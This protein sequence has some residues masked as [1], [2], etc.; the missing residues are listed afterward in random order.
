MKNTESFI[1]WSVTTD[2]TV[3]AQTVFSSFENIDSLPAIPQQQRY[4][5]A[6]LFFH[7]TV[8]RPKYHPAYAK[9]LNLAFNVLTA[10][11][12]ILQSV[13]INQLKVNNCYAIVNN[14]DDNAYDDEKSASDTSNV[15][16]FHFSLDN[17][18]YADILHFCEI[19]S[20]TGRE[21][22]VTKMNERQFIHY[23]EYIT[24]TDNTNIQRSYHEVSNLVFKRCPD[25]PSLPFY[26]EFAFNHGSILLGPSINGVY[27]RW[28]NLNRRPIDYAN[29][30]FRIAESALQLEIGT[31]EQK[32]KQLNFHFHPDKLL[33]KYHHAYQPFITIAHTVLQTAWALIKEDIQNSASDSE[34]E[35]EY[36]N[37]IVK[38]N[39]DL[40]VNIEFPNDTKLPQMKQVIDCCIMSIAV[41][42][43]SE[44]MDNADKIIKSDDT[45]NFDSLSKSLDLLLQ[46]IQ[47]MDIS[48]PNQNQLKDL[49]VFE[50][51]SHQVIKTVPSPDLQSNIPSQSST[52]NSGFLSSAQSLMQHTIQATSDKYVITFR[53]SAHFFVH[54]NFQYFTDQNQMDLSQVTTLIRDLII[55]TVQSDL[56]CYASNCPSVST[57]L[58][59]LHHTLPQLC[60]ICRTLEEG[61]IH[62][63]AIQTNRGQF[64]IG[65]F[66]VE[67]VGDMP[68]LYNRPRNV[69]YYT[70]SWYQQIH[71]IGISP[72]LLN[73]TM[74]N[75]CNYIVTF[76]R[77]TSVSVS[78][79]VQY[80]PATSTI[81]DI[82]L[83]LSEALNSSFH[84]P[85]IYAESQLH[86]LDHNPVLAATNLSQ[87]I[88]TD[89][90]VLIHVTSKSPLIQTDNSEV[91]RILF[92]QYSIQRSSAN[93][94]GREQ[95]P[96]F[97]RREHSDACDVCIVQQDIMS[98]IP[99]GNRTQGFDT[100][101][102]NFHAYIIRFCAIPLDSTPT[103]ARFASFEYLSFDNHRGVGYIRW[104]ISQTTAIATSNIQFH[105]DNHPNLHL[106]FNRSKTLGELCDV[107]LNARNDHIRV[108][109]EPTRGVHHSLGV[110]TVERVGTLRPQLQPPYLTGTVRY[111][112]TYADYDESGFYYDHLKLQSVDMVSEIYEISLQLPFLTETFTK[113]ILSDT[114]ISE[115]M[116]W[117]DTI[118][119]QYHLSSFASPSDQLH[120]TNGYAISADTSLG[121]VEIDHNQPIYILSRKSLAI[122]FH[123][124]YTRL[125]HALYYVRRK[126]TQ[127]HK[128]ATVS[129]STSNLN[130][131]VDSEQNSSTHL[132]Q[133]TPDV[134]DL[135]AAFMYVESHAGS[136]R[137]NSSSS[138]TMCDSGC[139][140][141]VFPSLDLFVEQK[142]QR[143]EIITAKADCR[144]IS[145]IRGTVKL[146]VIDRMGHTISLTISPVL[147][148]PECDMPLLSV[149]SL[150]KQGFHVV[151]APT[152]AGIFCDAT[153]MIPFYKIRNMWFL[154]I[155]DSPPPFTYAM[156]VQRPDISLQVL[157]HLTL[158]HASPRVIYET[159]QISKHIPKLPM[160]SDTHFCPICAQSKM[161]ARNTPPPS[162]HRTIAPG[163]L[164]HYDISFLET[165]TLHG[166]KLISNFIDDHT[167]HKWKFLHQHRDANTIRRIFNQ[168]L[169][170][171]KSIR[172]KNKE[173]MRVAR[174]RSD[175]GAEITG[176]MMAEWSAENHI[177]QET[178]APHTPS[179]NGKAEVTAGNSSTVS[180]SMQITANTLAILQ[181]YAIHYATYIENRLYSAA[182]SHRQGYNTSP[183]QELYNEP[184]S[185]QNWYPFG[186]AAYYYLGKRQNPGWK[187]QARGITSLCVGLGNWQG[188]KA[189]LL[190][191]PL[192]HTT[193]ASVNVKF[194]SSFFPCRPRGYRRIV[195]WDMDTQS[196]HFEQQPVENDIMLPAETLIVTTID[197][198]ITPAEQLIII[199]RDWIIDEEEPEEYI[200]TLQPSSGENFVIN[201][202]LLPQQIENIPAQINRNSSQDTNQVL[203]HLPPSSNHT[204]TQYFDED[205]GE[206]QEK[207]LT[208]VTQV[209]PL[210]DTSADHVT[211]VP[212]QILPDVF[213][214]S[215]PLGL[216]VSIQQEID[217]LY[218]PLE[219]IIFSYGATFPRSYT[220]R[221][222]RSLKEAKTFPD[223]PQWKIAHDKEFDAVES[224]G[225]YIWVNKPINKYIHHCHELFDIKT[226]N[227]GNPIKHKCR[228]VL[229]GNTQK[230]GESYFEVYAPVTTPEAIR[231]L[232]SVANQRDWGLRQFDFSTAYLN[233]PLEEEIY[234]YPPIG[235]DDP[236]GLGRIWR[237]IKSLYGA[238][239]SA[240]NW[241][242]LLATLFKEFGLRLISEA[243]Y[244]WAND[245]F[246]LATHVDDLALA[247]RNDSS[248]ETFKQF[249]AD[250]HCTMNDIGEIAQFLGIEVHRDRSRGLLQ[251]TQAGFV[252]QALERYSMLDAKPR[253][254]PLDTG[255]K[256]SRK[257]EPKCNE[258]EK[259]QYHEILGIIGWKTA[260]TGPGLAFSHSFLSRFLVSPA[261]QHLQAAKNVLR[262][263]KYTQYKGPVYRRDDF[264]ISTQK[265]NQLL[266]FA[267]A[268]HGMC[269]DSYRSTSGQLILLN[270][271]A[272]YWKSQLQN[273]AAISTTEAEYITLSENA[274]TVVG[275]RFLMEGLQEP[276]LGPTFIFQDN[277]AAI[278]ASKNA[279]NRSRLRHINVRAYNI[280]DLVRAGDVYPIQ[281]SSADQHADLC[282]KA[283][284]APILTRHT[285]VAHGERS[286]DPPL[287]PI[288]APEPA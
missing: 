199:P 56:V 159:S 272:I 242:S 45:L 271:A 142:Q 244:L 223:W 182:L 212:D 275:L 3:M 89:A 178:T 228:L 175:N 234:A 147:Y 239:Q 123:G 276:Q 211:S 181:G 288:P 50:V 284:A 149:D 251:I 192:E 261:V 269:L 116:P 17:M 143:T 263:M 180:R 4:L 59:S 141:S 174:L 265:P 57:Q 246:I 38:P 254:I 68:Q 119:T 268:D 11:H 216:P 166:C 103:S 76:V 259:K 51:T 230:Y 187:R 280:R 9:Y 63:D 40:Q 81:Y 34:S 31:L 114:T 255:L 94:N 161:R 164:I 62:L 121:G 37:N 168:F 129:V 135:S 214:V 102:P 283:L 42:H 26:L 108:H 171:V 215:G 158:G 145:E 79:Q 218:N 185:F 177:V 12:D 247:Y 98:S 241:N 179:Q 148:A 257:D 39:I 193:I 169:A 80:F 66:T 2:I 25:S 70:P 250:H 21:I 220:A 287:F 86:F 160:P 235:V 33:T 274:N 133:I 282:T 173:P 165:P 120:F 54:N 209:T 196:T 256:F 156:K 210:N 83:W 112:E 20:L 49:N 206:E 240:R 127:S 13:P 184:A 111:I 217:D 24:R 152:Y 118:L 195:N 27:Q 36:D 191:N 19:S 238:K 113:E 213:N 69:Y 88:L 189:F 172:L 117:F 52:I 96:L 8:T 139:E 245:D 75:D 29:R 64:P 225:T 72:C 151:F 60:T 226:D 115:L 130:T 194:D 84:E 46:Q 137:T 128:R 197:D 55:V 253:A 65:C 221:L 248:L 224:Q 154:P 163:D 14:V 100:D 90:P 61:A 126:S 107:C 150:N 134:V 231:I 286:T 73:S 48:I 106:Q 207:T 267:D 260:W 222:P 167:S 204:G 273:Q 28:S 190:Y 41:Q 281:C 124:S 229:Q 144:I 7:S 140:L 264:L 44:N 131:D 205:I 53:G 58:Q 227:F 252:K 77:N 279:P 201:Q 92:G 132:F 270:G 243:H 122:P 71:S 188:K 203:I 202:Q 170:I 78:D 82:Q 237:L 23:C 266:S 183:Y 109:A 138:W 232:F 162:E 110:I 208:L 233:A 262:Y 200:Y 136:V 258:Q 35:D 198:S 95:P 249:F 91:T 15:P 104:L 105:C 47:F 278:A 16:Q 93:K 1:K 236:E 277:T 153:T 155:N 99:I 67:K 146:P 18:T 87:I 186:C 10:A 74:P 219:D 285:D 22:L 30:V 5:R 97:N 85:M 6:C 101:R 125:F 176:K 43:D 157:W 32:Y